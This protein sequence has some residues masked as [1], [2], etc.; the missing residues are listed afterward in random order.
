MPSSHTLALPRLDSAPHLCSELRTTDAM[1][2]SS[3]SYPM[4]VSI[5][6]GIVTVD[7]GRRE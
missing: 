2:D 5:Q 4:G 1:G 7:P 3:S 6:P